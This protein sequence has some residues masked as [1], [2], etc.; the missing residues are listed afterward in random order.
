MYTIYSIVCKD[1]ATDYTYVDFTRN[2]AKIKYC[3]KH[4]SLH[5]LSQPYKHIRDFGGWTNWELTMLDT[6]DC[7]SDADVIV[8]RCKSGLP[9]TNTNIRYDCSVCHFVCSKNAD[10]ERHMNTTKHKRRTAIIPEPELPR[11]IRDILISN[12]TS[13]QLMN[14]IVKSNQQLQQQIVELTNKPMVQQITNV[15]QQN[16]Q[17]NSF[18][19]QVFLD[20]KCGDAMNLSAFLKTLAITNEDLVRNTEIGFV[21]G[22]SAIIKREMCDKLPVNKRPVHC[23]DIKRET[24]YYRENDKW[25]KEEGRGLPPPCD[26]PHQRGRVGKGTVGSLHERHPL[27]VQSVVR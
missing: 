13:Q 24:V 7:V 9:N 12:H 4:N 3:H 6:T 14:E 18:N 2:L 21:A 22:M 19:I 17:N 27:Q 8:Q 26:P 15:V 16:T 11:F 20:E 5:K 25:H 23:T 1:G 10:Y